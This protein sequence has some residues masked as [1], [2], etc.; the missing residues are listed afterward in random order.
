MRRR[1]TEAHIHLPWTG[2]RWEQVGNMSHQPCLPRWKHS[3]ND[4]E[5]SWVQQ[6]SMVCG[7]CESSIK[8][9]RKDFLSSETPFWNRA[10]SIILSI[11]CV[12]VLSLCAMRNLLFLEH[13]EVSWKNSCRRRSTMQCRETPYLTSEQMEVLSWCGRVDH[14]HVSIVTINPIFFAIRE[15]NIDRRFEIFLNRTSNESPVRIARYG[16][17]YGRVLHHP[18]R[19]AITEQSL[20]GSEISLKERNIDH[21]WDDR[22]GNP[23]FPVADVIVDDDLCA[24]EEITELCFPDDQIL[25]MMN[26]EA[27]VKAQ[28]C[29]FR[30]NTV[31]DLAENQQCTNESLH[32]STSKNPW[33]ESRALSGT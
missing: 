11:C 5:G 25:R 14:L 6:R 19:A 12:L 3:P 4:A 1:T 18:C 29:F 22:S 8:H 9:E 23:T 24:I 32:R 20:I 15:L 31:A 30:E 33:F 7:N 27:V 16:N 26:T 10:V 13:E 21:R 28:N 17:C 2:Y